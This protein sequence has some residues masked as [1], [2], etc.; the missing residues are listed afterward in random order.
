MHPTSKHV[1]LDFSLLR[2][3]LTQSGPAHN[4]GREVLMVEKVMKT[5]VPWSTLEVI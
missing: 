1:Y 3:F 5:D 2:L 4:S